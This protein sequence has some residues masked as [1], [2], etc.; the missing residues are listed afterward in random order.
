MEATILNKKNVLTSTIAFALSMSAH[1]ENLPNI[2][3]ILR[4]IEPPKIQEETKPELPQIQGM[5]IEPPLT[6]LPS[7][8]KVLVKTFEIIGNREIEKSELESLI[9]ED[10]NKEYNLAELELI[11]QKL[12]KYYRSKGYFVARAYLPAQEVENN[13]IKIRIVEGN[14]GQFHLKNDSLVRDSLVQSMLDDVKDYDIVSLDTLERAMLII[15]DTPGAQ[16]ARADVMPGDKVGT[17]DFAVDAVATSR[18]NGFVM[19]D[20]YGSIYTGEHRFSLNYDLNS[21]TGSGDRLSF[22]GMATENADLLNGRLGYSSFL[23]PNGLRGEVALSY[24]QYAL[25]DTY[26]SLDAQGTAKGLEATLTY[27]LRRIRA[28]TIEASFGFSGK[29]LED[30]VKSVNTENP[31]DN[32]SLTAGINIRDERSLLGFDGL[33]TASF[34]ASVGDLSINDAISKEND[35]KGAKMNGIYSKAV[36]NLSRATLLPEKFTLNTS[37]KMQHSLNG[38]NLDSSERMSVSGQNGVYAYPIGELIGTNAR[39]IKVELSRL[40]PAVEKLQH[41]WSIFASHGYA[42]AEHP[43]ITGSDAGRDINDVGI[44]WK[45]NYQNLIVNSHLAY[46]LDEKKPVSEQEDR[47]RFL[48]QVGYVF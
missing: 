27:P 40:L 46:R 24:T 2:G 37:F 8:K 28:Q 22:T 32:L 18:H 29:Q 42:E 39:L 20:N 16:I 33:T 38:K 23:M 14:Y 7:G 4:Q 25:G 15:N 48:V 17:S 41:N 35:A 12:T 10:A 31:R 9:A 5:P 45:G 43:T 3:D 36:L 34:Q 6:A 30:K 21:P 19:Y 44:G 26:S 47:V 1:A 11:T 13:L